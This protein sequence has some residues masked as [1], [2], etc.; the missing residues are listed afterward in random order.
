MLAELHKT[1]LARAEDDQIL[2]DA[3]QVGA[4]HGGSEEHVG[5]KVAIAHRI[6]RVRR[7]RLE[8]ERSLEQRA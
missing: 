1:E 5:D 4:D 2:G 7:H 6:D 8:S 3:R